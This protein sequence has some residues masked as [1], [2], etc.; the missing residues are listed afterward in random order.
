MLNLYAILAVLPMVAV[1]KVLKEY[2]NYYPT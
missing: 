1:G 2:N